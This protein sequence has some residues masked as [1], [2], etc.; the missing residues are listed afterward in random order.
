[1]EQDSTLSLSQELEEVRKAHRL[2]HSFQERMLSIIKFIQ[3]RLDFPE[4]YGYK[5][6]SNPIK[7]YMRG[8]HQD[9]MEIYSDMWAWDFIYSYVFEYYLGE[10]TSKKGDEFAMSIIQYSDTGYFETDNDEKN[11]PLSFAPVEK[12]AS[13][14]LFI[15]ELKPKKVKTWVWNIDELCMTKDYASKKHTKTIIE[16][17]KGNKQLLYSIPL[18]EFTDEQYALKALRQYAEFCCQ[19]AGFD[20]NDFNLD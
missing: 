19:Y 20:M 8:S 2:I 3:T 4:F 14:L 13:K 18:E 6:F 15:L 11:V 7:I 9:Y 10:R 12:S 1:M 16:H 17:P 5:Q